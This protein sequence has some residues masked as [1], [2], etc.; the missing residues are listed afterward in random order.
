MVQRTFFSK[1]THKSWWL[2][3]YAASSVLAIP[4]QTLVD[5][6]IRHMVLDIDDT[7]V[8]LRGDQLSPAYIRYFKKVQRAHITLSIGSNT[9]RDI[10]SIARSI[11]A[12][13]IP[14]PW[15]SYKPMRAFYKRV[16]AQ[17]HEMPG[18]IMMVGDRVIQ[19]VI[20]ANHAGL[21]TVLVV[22]LKR[23][24]GW[25]SRQYWRYLASRYEDENR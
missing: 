22:P 24:S 14:H 7:L 13:V 1:L 16:I 23:Q 4:I 17:T 20:G 5:A 8:P 6:N 15:W 10:T 3:T 25:F 12:A 11:D 18:S 21:T 9:R 2:P 19:D